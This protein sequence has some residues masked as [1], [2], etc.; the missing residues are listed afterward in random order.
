[1]WVTDAGSRTPDCL[2]HRLNRLM[3]TNHPV[4]KTLLQ[5]RQLDR[6]GSLELLQWDTGHLAHRASHVIDLDSHEIALTLLLFQVTNQ[7][8][9]LAEAHLVESGMLI[10]FLSHSPFHIFG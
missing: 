2:S 4:A 9:E 7:I 8:F 1:M 10:I 3:L 6:L 5:I